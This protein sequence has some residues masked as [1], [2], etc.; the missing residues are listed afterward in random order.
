MK[1]CE[2]CKVREGRP[3]STF[4][5]DVKILCP[6]CA[7]IYNSSI[8]K[9][10]FGFTQSDK[11]DFLY[12]DAMY[13]TDEAEEPEEPVKPF[14]IPTP[15]E[16]KKKLD[17]YVIGQEEAKRVLS[18]AVYNH[19]KRL[20]ANKEN[21]NT[22]IQKSNVLLVGPTGSGKTL[23]AQ[24]LADM[25]EVP[26]AIADATSLTEAGY[27]GD[28][29]ENILTQLITKA[30]GDIKKAE[31]GIIYIDEID[32]IGR[33]SENT[34]ITRD[35]S[36]EGVQQ[37]LLKIIEG[38]EV[39]VPISGGRKHPTASNPIINTKNILF[40][41][42][43]AFEGL[44]KIVKK[45][46]ETKT[47]IGFNAQEITSDETPEVEPDDLIKFGMMPELIGRL[48]NIV[49]LNEL[50]EKDLIRILK[51]PKNAL[52][53]QYEELFAMDNIAFRVEDAAL[54]AIAKKAIKR[55]SGARGLRSITE[56]I[57]MDAM[58]EAPSDYRIKEVIITEESVESKKVRYV[59]KQEA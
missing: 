35:V 51:E 42:G 59:K 41:C 4:A 10:V 58:F 22:T 19:Y 20:K 40:I 16:I 43:G 38:A 56:S 44:D 49:E 2:M 31:R 50:T 23:L 9:Q 29:V 45:K 3:L 28:D 57:I 30:D 5:G 24:T 46:C 6:E 37:A 11:E 7:K 12:A 33:K 52:L 21:A 18:V 13:E 55:K 27:V 15:K 8:A 17:A 36:G 48:T 39:S 53:K 54:Q 25:M 32:K 34:S 26:F 47:S 14:E 1:K